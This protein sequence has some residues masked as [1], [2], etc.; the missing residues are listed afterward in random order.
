MFAFHQGWTKSS[1][2][3]NWIKTST[4]KQLVQLWKFL[5]VFFWFPTFSLC[6][7]PL[8]HNKLRS[9]NW[10]SARTHH[11]HPVFLHAQQFDLGS[12]WVDCR[13]WSSMELLTMPYQNLL[14]WFEKSHVW[15]IT[16]ELPWTILH[17]V[18][19]IRSADNW[20]KTGLFGLSL[21]ME[22]GCFHSQPVPHL[23]FWL[24]D[25]IP[26]TS[27]I[28]LYYIMI[29]NLSISLFPSLCSFMTS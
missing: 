4:R 13:V 8:I 24:T 3:S 16:R 23:L 28:F 21:R 25:P 14:L 1:L 29:P 10:A 9:H 17:S 19:E 6:L 18:V 12:G 27:H 22:H 26:Y 7:N 11:N 2:C 15:L 5:V 20:C